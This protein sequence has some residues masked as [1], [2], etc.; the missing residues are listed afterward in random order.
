MPP[1]AP[2]QLQFQGPEPFT[3]L[4]LPTL[5]KSAFG[6]VLKLLPFALP[7][8]A[9]IGAAFFFAL[10]A[11]L[12][13]PLVPPQ[14][15]F[16]GPEPLTELALPMLHKSVLGAVLKLLPFAPPQ[17]ALMGGGA[18]FFAL[19]DALRPPL[20][21]LQ[22]QFHG[23]VPLNPLGLPALHRLLVG[24]DI[25][26]LPFALPQTPLTVLDGAWLTL[27]RVTVEGVESSNAS[28]GAACPIADNSNERIRRY[29]ICPPFKK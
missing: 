15:Q 19:Q 22:L 14:L 4:A 3:E 1:L 24:G 27:V 6:A 25:S 16:Q 9:L 29:F 21:P 2:P 20:V 8:E 11:A 26:K 12:V 13:P 23:P 28:G 18:F 17:E 5:H 10:Q 7:Q